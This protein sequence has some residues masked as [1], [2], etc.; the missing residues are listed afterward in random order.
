MW[1][2]VNGWAVP[3]I[4]KEHIALFFRDQEVHEDWHNVM[5]QGYVGQVCWL[6]DGW[7]SW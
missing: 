1:H 6:V 7:S 2:I 3:N 4:S 5:S